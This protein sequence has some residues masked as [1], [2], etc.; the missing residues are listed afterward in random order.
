VRPGYA[1]GRQIAFQRLKEPRQA[2]FA[3][4]ALFENGW[5]TALDLDAKAARAPIATFG[6]GH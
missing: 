5:M 4:A 3:G 2:G 1:P 6:S